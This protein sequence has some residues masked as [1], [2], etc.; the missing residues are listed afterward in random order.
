M[1]AVRL[2]L[3]SLFIFIGGAASALDASPENDKSIGTEAVFGKVFR[4]DSK[5]PIQNVTVTAILLNRKEKYTI[6]DTEGEFGIDELK[7][8]TYK[9][10]FEKDGYR[11]VVKEKV[12]IRQNEPMELNVEMEFLNYNLVPS[13][14]HFFL[15]DQP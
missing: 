9:I 4:E 3:T 15:V 10:I 13:P 6:T 5:K 12:N 7:P 11:K 8:G 14:F 2:T 1:K